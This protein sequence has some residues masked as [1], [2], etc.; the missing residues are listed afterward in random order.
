MEQKTKWQKRVRWF[1][2][3]AVI[4]FTLVMTA[5]LFVLFQSVASDP[6]Q[7]KVWLE[8][9]GWLGRAVLALSLIHSYSVSAAGRAFENGSGRFVTTKL[10][11]RSGSGKIRTMS[12]IS[13]AGGE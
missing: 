9:F 1:S 11:L 4:I 10:T 2:I 8:Q 6:A 3:G 12:S 7:F 13:G 5:V